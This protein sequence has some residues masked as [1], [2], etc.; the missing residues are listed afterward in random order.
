[1]VEEQPVTIAWRRPDERRHV[2]IRPVGA[3]DVAR[4][5]RFYAELSDESRALR[6]LHATRGIRPD[7]ARIFCTTDHRHRE[8]FLAIVGPEDDWAVVGH[9]CIEPNDQLPD[10]SGDSAEIAVA[11]ADRWQRMG[12][13]RALVE[14]AISW[15]R[16]ARIQRLT[17]IVSGSNVAMARLLNGLS[18]PVRRRCL[19]DVIVVEIDLDARPA[20]ATESHTPAAA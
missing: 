16:R 9:L 14:S 13:G 1:M 20:V 12:I 10:A 7:Q 8:G 11:V 15:S 19:S 17:G 5:E 4:L 6:F 3:G 2:R 18:V